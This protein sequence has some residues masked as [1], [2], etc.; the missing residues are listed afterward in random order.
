[1]PSTTT[2]PQWPTSA[3]QGT[4]GYG[5]LQNGD[6]ELRDI[7]II[8]RRRK[9]IV[10]LACVVGIVLAVVV[11][12]FSQKEF[13]S[14]ATIEINKESG[15]ELGM[16]DLSGIASGLGGENEANMDLLTEQA[17]I[18][19]E[20]T[21]L[22]VVE[23]LKLDETPPYAI[24]PDAVG[25]ESELG[26]ERG[27][28]LEKAPL[29]RDRLVGM[30]K[31]RLR[32]SLIKGTR[33]I[34]VTYTD[35]DPGRSTAIANAVVDAYMNEYT[36]ARYQASSRASS[37]LT[38][39][40]TDL[41]DKVA[42]SQAKADQF[43]RDSGLTG[44]TVS[45]SSGKPGEQGA[46]QS[47]SENVPLE[48]L[49]ELNRDLTSAEVSRIAKEAIFKMAETQ[50]PDVV[51]GIGSSALAND[52]GAESTFAHGN[53]DLALLQ[54]LRQQKAQI[55][56]EL[57]ASSV[58][59]GAKNPAII[60][61]QDESASIDTQIHAE[62]DRIRARAKNDLDLARLAESGIQQQISVQEQE[63]NKITEKG[64]QLVLLQEEALSNKEIYQDLY[65]KLE[66]ASVTAGMKASNVTLVNPARAPS[67]PSS[68]RRRLVL[69]LGG[70][71][72]LVFGLIGAFLWDYFDDSIKT[73]EQ[74]EQITSI[75]IV[76][77]IPDF[78]QKQSAAEKYGL[79]P[80]KAA[81]AQEEASA[82]WLIRSPRSHIAEAYRTLRTA[83]LLSKIDNPP[84]VMLIMSG[85]PVEGK[86]TTCL[87]TAVAF[88]L[89]GD[90]VLYLDADL[91]RPRAHTT[92]NCSNDVGLSNCLTGSL[93]FQ[94]ALK[95]H[96][97]VETLF[98]LPAGP[99]P[100]NPSE[101]L[102][103]KRFAE[104]IGELR[105]NFDY[106]F[107]DSPPV[108]LVTDAQLLSSVVD[109]YI[110]VLRMNKTTKRALQRS[111]SLMKATGTSAL[112]VVVNALSAN[113]ATYSSYG[114]YG[115]GSGYY[116]DE[117]E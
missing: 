105:Q 32:V 91:R 16:V 55:G 20:N 65:S 1:M 25:K 98:L 62:L 38:N 51:L 3:K 117:Q 92:F 48:R 64:D 18:M 73:P 115:K 42:T 57:A 60:Q 4:G 15:N 82:S 70:L 21:A 22:N 114:Y 58:K 101:L 67:L 85:S 40:L 112:G 8:L 12:L 56:V 37:W 89:R 83:L 28:P 10:I 54:Q 94:S 99:H 86:S 46:V 116:A 29:Q 76:G 106:V 43:Q 69:G 104:L 35:T 30:F 27:L 53:A 80:A 81:G 66:E 52:P 110:L 19:S 59:Y 72:G 71:L 111:L 7:A 49:L 50:D 100:P 2:S 13:S 75:P 45:P 17:V 36:Q 41:K 95:P 88:A 87:N 78:A 109:G 24:P 31:S 113:S 44:V 93:N 68:P 14:T 61:L 9:A 103:S 102:G 107:I 5:L 33:L 77:A 97:D 23:Q 11:L 108:L 90:K 74:V 39:E 34:D 6:L 63:V 84:K 96:P 26:R 79:A 47:S